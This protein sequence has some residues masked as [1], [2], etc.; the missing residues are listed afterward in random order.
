MKKRPGRKGVPD[1]APKGSIS[2]QLSCRNE[3]QKRISAGSKPDY[4]P[5]VTVTFP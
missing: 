2:E 4:T 3:I 1:T 5:A